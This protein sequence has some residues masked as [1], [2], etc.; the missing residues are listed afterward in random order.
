VAQSIE[1]FS[2]PPVPISLRQDLLGISYCRTN[3]L[4]QWDEIS[5]KKT[6]HMTI[7]SPVFASNCNKGRDLYVEKS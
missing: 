6:P 1:P 7:S 5:A 4:E 2:A 3:F